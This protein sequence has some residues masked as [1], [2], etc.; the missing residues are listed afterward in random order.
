MNRSYNSSNAHK[1]NE[2]YFGQP[3]RR[4]DS[5]EKSIS[6]YG[7]AN[8]AR[9]KK[10]AEIERKRN[11]ALKKAQKI[12]RMIAT[13]FRVVVVFILCAF[14][15][16][17]YVLITEMKMVANDLKCEYTELV[18]ENQM[19]QNSIDSAVDLKKLQEIATTQLGMVRPAADQII[20]I[21]NVNESYGEKVDKKS[22]DDAEEIPEED[23]A[24]NG[25]PGSI[26]RFVTGK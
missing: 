22:K 1:Y 5:A 17:R 9:Y 10:R 20:Q 4:F 23:S 18:N 6:H 16:Y 26:I 3:Q 13:S 2:Y 8:S 19:I 7:S 15:V 21:E 11:I 25:A 14:L 24:L 12:E